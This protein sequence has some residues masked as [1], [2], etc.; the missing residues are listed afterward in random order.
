MSGALLRLPTLTRCPQ[1]GSSFCNAVRCLRSGVTHAEHEARPD[2]A[3]RRGERCLIGCR[4]EG[5]CL[6]AA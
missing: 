3:Y 6:P 5:K 2:C 1:C 4:M